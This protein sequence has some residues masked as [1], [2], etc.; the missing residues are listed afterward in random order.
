[1]NEKMKEKLYRASY[2]IKA[3]EGGLRRCSEE[4][5]INI[6]ILKGTNSHKMGLHIH[7]NGMSKIA[8][9]LKELSDKGK[10]EN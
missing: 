9:K 10:R 3:D 8:N 7:R 5:K 6:Y 1:M 2:T 4:R